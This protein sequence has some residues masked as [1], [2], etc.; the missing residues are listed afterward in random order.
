MFA[1]KG[2]ERFL[3]DEIIFKGHTQSSAVIQLHRSQDI[4]LALCTSNYYTVNH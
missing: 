3:V 2:S 4:P 1:E